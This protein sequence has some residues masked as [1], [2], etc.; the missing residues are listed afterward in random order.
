M[1]YIF[2]SINITQNVYFVLFLVFIILFVFN[3]RLKL[4]DI[5]EKSYP[6]A[7]Y[8]QQ[9]SFTFCVCYSIYFCF[10]F[11]SHVT[12]RIRNSCG[13]ILS[14]VKC[15]YT[16]FVPCSTIMQSLGFLV[17][18]N[19][20]NESRMMPI[21]LYHPTHNSINRF[22]ISIINYQLAWHCILLLM[23]FRC[24]KQCY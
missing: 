14:I 16:T 21:K 7:I 13:T 24:Y 19:K 9:V 11:A 5:V 6:T 15:P 2:C 4:I 23:H 17:V 22:N 8:C 20:P 1:L 18:R 3:N 12:V 10:F